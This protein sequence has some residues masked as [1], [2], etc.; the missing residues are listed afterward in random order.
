MNPAFRRIW[1][2]VEVCAVTFGVIPLLTLGVYRLFPRFETWQTATLGFPFAVFVYVMMV[3]I[4]LLIVC[5]RRENLAAYGLTFQN[6]KYHVDIAATCFIPVALANLPFGLGV[7]HTRWGGALI[8]AVVQIAL[9][10]IVARVLRAKPSAASVG[11]LGMVLLPQLVA[12][13]VAGK[14]LVTFL[15]YALFVG[16]GEEILYRGYIH[17]RLNAAFGK[18]FTF[19]DVTYGWGSLIAALIFG[20]TH[21]GILRSMLGISGVM[22]WAWGF[23][24]FFGGLVFAYVREKSGS[25]LA[26]A[27]LHGLPQAIATVVL[28]FF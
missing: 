2:V 11:L 10:F 9:L 18:P 3:I 21:I 8:L 4:C 20:L 7:D 14:A 17:S 16:F 13:N 23:W 6:P 1:A 22:T 25:I 5:L 24:T 12:G 19:H 15:T 28:L 26:P 27:L